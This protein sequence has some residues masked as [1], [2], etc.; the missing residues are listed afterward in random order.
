MK[1]SIKFSLLVAVLFFTTSI[2]AQ[3]TFGNVQNSIPRD[4]DGINK[5]D[6]IKDNEQFKGISV[7]MGGAFALQFQA[8][9]S[10]NDQTQGTYTASNGTAITN[11]KLKL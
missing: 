9:N 2:T 3:T 5:F 1:T 6:V 4:K 11:Y 7:Y 10:F 8:L